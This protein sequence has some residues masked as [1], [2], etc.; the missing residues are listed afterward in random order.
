MAQAFH[1]RLAEFEAEPQLKAPKECSPQNGRAKLNKRAAMKQKSLTCSICPYK[2]RQVRVTS[3]PDGF[4]QRSAFKTIRSVSCD[5]LPSSPYRDKN[6][7]NNDPHRITQL[8]WGYFVIFS[9]A[10]N[11]AWHT[12][13][14]FSLGL[15][16]VLLGW[17]NRCRRP[18]RVEEVKSTSLF[19]L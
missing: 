11:F 7:K 5:T 8:L 2:Q 18:L 3:P 6:N 9:V 19:D 10:S 15:W 13:A 4:K 17:K 14:V 1:E 12:R 16:T